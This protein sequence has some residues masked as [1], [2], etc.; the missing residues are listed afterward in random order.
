MYL[1]GKSRLG[2]NATAKPQKQSARRGKERRKILEQGSRRRRRMNRGNTNLSAEIRA[3]SGF[4]S[5]ALLLR[6]CCGRTEGRKGWL[7]LEQSW[8]PPAHRS[9]G[10]QL[11][12]AASRGTQVPGQKS[13][14]GRSAAA[15]VSHIQEKQ[16]KDPSPAPARLRSPLVAFGLAVAAS[17]PGPLRWPRL[18]QPRGAES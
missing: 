15:R 16:V 6:L 12:P 4:F 13:G 9:W 10:T 5:S 1:G 8:L 14:G 11:R 7:G 3:P 2:A 18:L 17:S